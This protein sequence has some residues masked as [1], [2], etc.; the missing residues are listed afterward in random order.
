[1]IGMVVLKL[2]LLKHVKLV[3]R[4][5]IPIVLYTQIGKEIFWREN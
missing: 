5:F 4:F 2:M 1:M 3:S